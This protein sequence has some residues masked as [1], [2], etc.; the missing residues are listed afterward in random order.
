VAPGDKNCKCADLCVPANQ[1]HTSYQITGAGGVTVTSNIHYS[2]AQ[3]AKCSTCLVTVPTLDGVN[4]V[5]V[6]FE[7]TADSGGIWTKDAKARFEL[8]IRTVPND[9]AKC[10]DNKMCLAGLAGADGSFSQAAQALKTSSRIQEMCLNAH[11]MHTQ[12]VNGGGSG[13]TVDQKCTQCHGDCDSDADCEAGLTCFQRSSSLQTVPGCAT[14]GSG[15]VSWMDYCYSPT[16]EIESISAT[17]TGSPTLNDVCAQWNQ[18]LK[19]A[20]KDGEIKAMLGA[21]NAEG[22]HLPAEFSG[23]VQ[24]VMDLQVGTGSADDA[25]GCQNPAI[26]D[27]E[28]WDCSCHEKMKD[29]CIPSMASSMAS[30]EFQDCY[31]CR[32]CKLDVVCDSWKASASCSTKCPE[33]DNLLSLMAIEDKSN[34]R[35]GWD[36]G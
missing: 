24:Q 13:C 34:A 4:E 28:A 26:L 30:Q 3:P 22:A 33:E 21:F 19:N 5:R 11:S 9:F 15:D 10:E 29:A 36:C 25:P 12:L 31:R 16:T 1:G 17:I 7:P 14:G 27:P 18:C 8:Q 35:V 32:L 23:V 6:E 20:G 2:A